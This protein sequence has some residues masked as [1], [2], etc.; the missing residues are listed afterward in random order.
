MTSTQTFKV[1]FDDH[2]DRITFLAP[3]PAI[4]TDESHRLKSGLRFRM[5]RLP[6]PRS[7][8]ATTPSP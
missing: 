6:S 4:E 3:R 1:V 8:P 5:S 2:E 7:L